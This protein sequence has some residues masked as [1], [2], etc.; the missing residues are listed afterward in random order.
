MTSFAVTPVSGSLI[1]SGSWKVRLENVAPNSY[2]ALTFAADPP[3]PSVSWMNPLLP[4]TAPD[5]TGHLNLQWNASRAGVVLA[6]DVCAELFYAPVIQPATFPSLNVSF[7]GNYQAAAGLGS[8]WNP[9]EPA[10]VAQDTN[11]DGVW[12]L[13]TSTIPAGDYEYKVALN[14]TWVVNYGLGGVRDGA[15]ITTTQPTTNAPLSF[16]FDSTDKFITTRP[17]SDIIVLVGDMM[18]E[19]G[20]ADWDAS[21]PGGLVEAHRR[22]AAIRADPAPAGRKLAV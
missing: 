11:H 13:D 6:D 15:N 5:G 8:N 3:A 17:Q 4:G 10:I 2:F 1:S 18:S 20:G 9:G 22:C 21:E 19:I 16:Y 12:K 14:G 7:P